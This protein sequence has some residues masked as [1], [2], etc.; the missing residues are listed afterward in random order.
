MDNL[1]IIVWDTT[2]IFNL[3]NLQQDGYNERMDIQ[4]SPINIDVNMFYEIIRG[5]FLTE[6]KIILFLENVDLNLYNKLKELK[7]IGITNIFPNL[8][9]IDQQDIIDEDG[10]LIMIIHNLNGIEFN[11][12]FITDQNGIVRLTLTNN[13]TPSFKLEHLRFPLD[14]SKIKQN[15]DQLLNIENNSSIKI[16]L[17]AY[18][19]LINQ[20]DE[21]L[22][23]FILENNKLRKKSMCDNY[24]YKKI[25]DQPI[26]YFEIK[27]KINHYIN[28]NLELSDIIYKSP[29]NF[30][31]ID[32][33]LSQLMNND[34]NNESSP[35]FPSFGSILEFN[36]DKSQILPISDDHKL[37]YTSSDYNTPSNITSN[38]YQNPYNAPNLSNQSLNIKPGELMEKKNEFS[39]PPV[40]TFTY[41][42]LV[43]SP[44]TTSSNLY[45]GSYA[46]AAPPQYYDIT[47]STSLV[48]NKIMS[49]VNV[50]MN[51][52]HQTNSYQTLV[53][54]NLYTTIGGHN[55]Y[56]SR[57]ITQLNKISQLRNLKKEKNKNRNITFK[58]KKKNC[59]LNKINKISR[60][61]YKIK[62]THF[63]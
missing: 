9:Y 12:Q 21:F 63:L 19:N 16:I 10:G 38:L 53:P 43:N 26:K 24:G 15:Y 3:I 41:P 33:N 50:P 28:T 39:L 36:V 48:P 35:K 58:K 17:V 27:S 54:P 11:S 37:K 49:P 7:E 31:M 8:I 62:N 18:L 61:I 2:S 40:E 42:Y 55:K 56:I 1:E 14:K 44:Q 59:N 25:N 13:N 23:H 32:K 4:Q 52:Y 29:F 47:P 57:P 34:D 30:S 60:K 20:E 22:D 46:L 5:F 45:Y 51:N 6:T